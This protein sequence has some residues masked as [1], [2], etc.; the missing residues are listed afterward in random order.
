MPVKYQLPVNWSMLM[1]DLLCGPFPQ[2]NVS[3]CCKSR[4]KC[5]VNSLTIFK[6]WLNTQLLREQVNI[7]TEK[8]SAFFF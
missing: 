6:K 7:G 1:S 8:S 2:V 4:M 3:L 5:L